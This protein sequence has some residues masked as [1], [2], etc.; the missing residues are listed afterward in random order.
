[1]TGRLCAFS[2]VTGAGPS[3]DVYLSNLP[4]AP[5]FLIAAFLLWRRPRHRVARRMLAVA[6]CAS[7]A[8]A[9]GEVLSVLWLVRGPQPWY[10]VLGAGSQVAELGGVAAG[11]G[12]VAVFPDGAYHR[13][14]ERWVVGALMVQV[15]VLPA[16]L[17]LSQPTVTF[18]P[19]MVWAR[20]AIASPL[21]AQSL[22]W[23]GPAAAAYYDSVFLWAVAGGLLLGLRYRRLPPELRLQVKWPLTTTI[24]FAGSSRSTSSSPTAQCLTGWASS[25]GTSPCSCSRSPSRS[26]GTALETTVDM[27]ELGMRLAST[28]RSALGLRWVRVS[29]HRVVDETVALDPIGWEGIS[30]RQTDLADAIVPLAH[31]RELVGSLSAGTKIRGE[32]A[33]TDRDLLAALGRQAALA[34]RHA[35]LASDLS[36]Q[37]ELMQVQALELAESRARIVRAQ[38]AERKRIERD[39]HDGVQQRLVNLAAR[40]RR[41][42]RMSSPDL[43]QLVRELA[44]EAAETVVALQDFSRGIYPSV[45]SD[46]GLSPALWSHAQ[47]LPMNVELD[48]APDVAGQR[49][50]REREAALYFV[51]LEAIVNAQKHASARQ[52]RV[53]L[54]RLGPDIRLEVIDDGS[55][56]AVHGRA[57]GSGLQNMKDRVAALGRSLE[58]HGRPGQGTRIVA[59]I[60]DGLSVKARQATPASR[61][62]PPPHDG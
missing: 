39:L 22:A 2:A 38:D 30:P 29:T 31:G 17:L 13:R 33:E 58:I 60:P 16:L 34:L 62:A 20:P 5:V 3:L 42:T 8:L 43:K 53:I 25:S 40:L 6:V 12:L 24:C 44:G 11:I 45:L 51:A 32:L 61:S 4:M 7:L 50:G 49:F 56:L 14:D 21:Y 52:I 36:D 46:E 55:G 59:S 9:L 28:I 41:A 54:R 18:D 35:R 37:L 57:Q 23:L 10:W 26:R 48:V 1:M 19:Y 27:A 15:G 47:R